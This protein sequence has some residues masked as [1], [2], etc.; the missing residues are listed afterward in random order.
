MIIESKDFHTV[1]S[2]MGIQLSENECDLIV[3]AVDADQN[4]AGPL[5]VEW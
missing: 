4:R 5:I 2:Q 1:F 3:D